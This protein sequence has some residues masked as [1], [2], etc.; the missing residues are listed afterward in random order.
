MVGVLGTEAEK[1]GTEEIVH[2][3]AGP[4]IVSTLRKYKFRV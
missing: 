1:K 2:E 3:P 4:G